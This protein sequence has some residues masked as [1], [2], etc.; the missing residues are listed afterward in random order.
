MV[1]INKYVKLE[2]VEEMIKIMKERD[3][4]MDFTQSYEECD[5]ELKTQIKYI[6]K[7]AIE[8]EER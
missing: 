4:Y 7:S 5:L 3:M 2:D 8:I 6:R 1:D